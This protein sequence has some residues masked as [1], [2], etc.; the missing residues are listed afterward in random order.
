[1]IKILVDTEEEKQEILGAS[2]M[3]HDRESVSPSTSNAMNILMHL[4]MAPNLISVEETQKVNDLVQAA[5]IAVA[6]LFVQDLSQKVISSDNAQ[7]ERNNLIKLIAKVENK[8]YIETCSCINDIA[9]LIR[10]RDENK[11]PKQSLT[12]YDQVKAAQQEVKTWP[13]SVKDGTEIY[14]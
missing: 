3:L 11:K 9:T 5:K 7:E 6:R 14:F 13:Q 2:R 8:T 1:M 10:L 12:L 4:Y